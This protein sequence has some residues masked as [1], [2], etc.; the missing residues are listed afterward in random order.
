MEETQGKTYVLQKDNLI[1]VKEDEMIRLSRG[2]NYVTLTPQFYDFLIAYG[3]GFTEELM[4]SVFKKDHEIIKAV[5]N[6]LLSGRI[7]RAM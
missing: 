4:T 6:R 3:D 5:I 7:V 1:C 2:Q